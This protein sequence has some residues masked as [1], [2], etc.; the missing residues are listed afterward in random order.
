MTVTRGFKA[1]LWDMD[2][3]LADSEPLHLRTLITALAHHGVEAG[4]ELHPLIFGKTGREV[5]ALVSER[6][7]IEIEFEAWSMFR[8]RA[9]LAAAPS[10]AARPGALE[11]YRAV[12]AAGVAQAVVSNASRMLLEANLAALDLQEPQLVTV[13]ANDVRMGKPDPEPYL[14]AAWLL[15]LEPREAI[16]VEDSPTGA[17]A[18]VAAGM[19]VLGWPLDDAAASAF[20]DSVRIVH[21][22]SELAHALGVEPAEWCASAEAIQSAAN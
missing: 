21:A 22:A 13:S 16:V 7:G 12:R 20:P 15:R 18:A 2:G 10:I 17:R 9:Y 8:A 4:D 19:R 3:T 1:V 11:V 6:F 14:R 5:H